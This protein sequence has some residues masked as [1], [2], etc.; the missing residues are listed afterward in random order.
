MSYSS[1]SCPD[2]LQEKQNYYDEGWWDGIQYGLTMKD[3]DNDI[4]PEEEQSVLI[5]IG[6]SFASAVYRTLYFQENG[7]QYYQKMFITCDGKQF[8]P[9]FIRY[10]MPHPIVPDNYTTT[11]K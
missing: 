2:P 6:D 7:Q 11:Y 1:Y 4:F 5:L 10:W 3:I 9:G 8:L